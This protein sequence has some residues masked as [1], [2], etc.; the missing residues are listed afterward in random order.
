MPKKLHRVYIFKP[1]RDNA[2]GKTI[3]TGD[4]ICMLYTMKLLTGDY[5]VET[6][7]DTL[8]PLKFSHTPDGLIPVG[9]N[10]EID[11]MKSGEKYR[12]F[13]PSSLAYGSYRHEGLFGANAN[14]IIDVDLK[15]VKTEDE[16]N[17]EEMDSVNSFVLHNY[18]EADAYSNALYVYNEVKGTGNAPSNDGGVTF[19]F[20]RKYLDGTVIESTL[21]SAPLQ[22]YFF[23]NR[24]VPGLE[25][26]IK[27][28]REGGKAILI[29]P[30]KLGFGA[31]IQ[32][33]PQKVRQKW[34]SDEQLEPKV[35]PYTPIMYEVELIGTM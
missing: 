35:R 19:N 9:L 14:F 7:S 11:Q 22:V 18:P 20:T 1:L 24:L 10:D 16:V 2:S 29:M 3:Q 4:V 27:Q 23:E 32:V 12:F 26:G 6:Y 34:V 17:Q 28:M 5:V 21:E 25:A 30:S 31:S 15:D 13:I 8:H 33:I